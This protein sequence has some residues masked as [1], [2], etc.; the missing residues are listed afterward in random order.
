MNPH[1]TVDA[2]EAVNAW[3]NRRPGQQDNEPADLTA[4]QHREQAGILLRN[5]FLA[6]GNEVPR[7]AE[8]RAAMVH[9]AQ[10]H[11]MIY[12]ADVQRQMAAGVH[13]ALDAARQADGEA[14]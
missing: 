5:A 13:A 14:S 9:A 8:Q 12:A 4:E 11:A 10:V 6:P 7:T 1:T 3:H 2:A